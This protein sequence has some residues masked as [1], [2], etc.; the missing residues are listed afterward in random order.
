MTLFAPC[1]VL[2]AALTHAIWSLSAKYAA[3]FAAFR[4][5]VLG[6]VVASD[7]DRRPDRRVV[8]RGCRGVCW[9]R[10]PEP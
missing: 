4:V 1:L 2:L 8:Q 10:G 5:A 9:I 7:R 3:A 6:G